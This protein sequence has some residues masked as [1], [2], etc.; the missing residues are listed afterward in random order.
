MTALDRHNLM[1]QT[2]AVDE[3]IDVVAVDNIDR[4]VA[5]AEAA[6]GDNVA[7]VENSF[8]KAHPS[9]YRLGTP[10]YNECWCCSPFPRHYL[11]IS[12]SSHYVAEHIDNHLSLIHI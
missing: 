8:S 1:G 4:N 9:C 3:N 11:T 5:F 12:T 2:I 6:D 7:V 10:V